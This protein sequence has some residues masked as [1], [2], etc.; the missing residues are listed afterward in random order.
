MIRELIAAAQLDEHTAAAYLGRSRRT[1]RRYLKLDTAPQPV[2]E[3]LR[4]VRWIAPESV[5]YLEYLAVL[6]GIEH[7]RRY[8]PTNTQSG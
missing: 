4:R 6:R 3:A 7:G 8:A 1:V 5:E 2:V